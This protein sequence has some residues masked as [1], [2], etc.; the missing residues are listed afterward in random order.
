MSGIGQSGWPDAM[1]RKN[2]KHAGV[3]PDTGFYRVDEDLE[4]DSIQKSYISKGKGVYCEEPEGTFKWSGTFPLLRPSGQK[5]YDPVFP[6]QQGGI[7]EVSGT[8]FFE[9]GGDFTIRRYASAPLT[10]APTW[11]SSNSDIRLHLPIAF[12]CMLC[13]CRPRANQT[14]TRLPGPPKWR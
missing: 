4:C 11:P 9:D 14:E 7:W 3:N 1:N 5:S 6:D 12:H 13:L 10:S 2:D 8:V